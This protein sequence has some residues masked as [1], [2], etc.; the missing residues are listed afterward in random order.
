MKLLP[1]ITSFVKDAAKSV[2]RISQQEFT[3]VADNTL[4]ELLG[5]A[6]L[7]VT[8][9]ALRR[10]GDEDVLHLRCAHREEVALCPHCGALSTKVHQEEPRCVR[11]LDVWGKKT[12]LHF[13]SRRFECDQC[14]K[15]FT[16]ELPFVD[17]HRRQS[18][19]FEMRVYQSCLTS[20]RKDVA[21]R[22]GLSQST[23][24]EI[25]NR[26]AALKKSVGVDG[27]TRVLGIDEISLKKRHKQFV[28]VISDI[29]RK[30]ILAVLPD[31]EKQ[32][33]ENWIESLSDQQKKAIR[34]VSIDMWAPYYQA[35]CNKLPHAKVV[36][37]RFHVMKQLN[38]RLTQLRTRFQRQCDPETQKIL[39]GSRWLIVRNRSELSTKQADHLDQI[40]ELCP[41]LRALYL[42]KEEF[43]TIF[44]KVRC[45]EKAARFLDVWCLKA[46]RTGDKYLSKFCKTLKNWR[47]QILNYFI[48]RI[49]N[50][51][52]EGTNN[53]LRAIIRMAFGYRNFNNFRIRVLAGLGDFHTN[54]R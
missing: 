9:Y 23:V 34:F 24:K 22:E 13:L 4:T 15:V 51:F 39:K 53:S 6:T 36:V 8:M 54:P 3:S 47:E 45:R 29:S 26:L 11:H 31:R 42:L 20:T 18:S 7:F 12:F 17:S 32:T 44:E 49:T 1:Y 25:F 10:E 41:D 16:E 46:E 33:L 50:G 48:E 2:K 40:L 38:H 35:A 5:I 52:V 27:L 30:C 37:D 43:R 14:G 19:A 28:L 21:K